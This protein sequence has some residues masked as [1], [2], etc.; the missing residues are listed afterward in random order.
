M[1]KSIL[2]IIFIFLISC[3]TNQKITYVK[4]PTKVEMNKY[5]LI[6]DRTS[7]ENFQRYFYYNTR[8]YKTYST[9][10]KYNSL[11]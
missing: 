11:K 1:K 3:K 10:K 6:K 8:Q 7:Q 4:D 2:F 5:Y 9:G